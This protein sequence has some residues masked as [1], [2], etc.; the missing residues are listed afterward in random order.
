MGKGVLGARVDIQN[1]HSCHPAGLSSWTHLGWSHLRLGHILNQSET[2]RPP[3]CPHH[4]PAL[5][6]LVSPNLN[7]VTLVN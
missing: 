2:L 3:C 1:P 7:I 4:T 5:S 6:V